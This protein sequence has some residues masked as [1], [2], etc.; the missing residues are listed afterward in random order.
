MWS[1]GPHSCLMKSNREDGNES[2]G[3]HQV[4][5]GAQGSGDQMVDLGKILIINA[6]EA[7]EKIEP[8]QEVSDWGRSLAKP[9]PSTAQPKY[10]GKCVFHEVHPAKH[11]PNVG[12]QTI[13][14]GVFACGTCEVPYE[15]Q[16]LTVPVV[17]VKQAAGP[18]Q[19]ASDSLGVGG[20]TGHGD[21]R[22][23]G[24]V[25]SRRARADWL[26]CASSLTVCTHS[27]SRRPRVKG[28]RPLAPGTRRQVVPQ[29]GLRLR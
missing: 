13:A 20:I 22:R 6:H 27:A 23:G 8:L 2:G 12:S 15:L 28:K 11:L 17:P 7:K 26:R 16:V 1:F 21:R 9:S 10:H 19:H 18:S 29:S 3:A 14:P 4:P 24:G 5:F 25:A